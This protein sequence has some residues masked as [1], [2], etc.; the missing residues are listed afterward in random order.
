MPY[1]YVLRPI[2]ACIW[3]ESGYGIVPTEFDVLVEKTLKDETLKEAVARL[4]A[5]KK[6]G[7]EL[8][9]GERIPVISDFLDH[10]IRRL[11]VGKEFL[12]ISKDFGMLDRVF[13]E[14]LK[15]VNGKTT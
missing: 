9:M 5:Q 2:L 6:A 10:E 11:S 15:S 8:D 7:N 3:I 4:M 14:I 13:L 1:F 12:P